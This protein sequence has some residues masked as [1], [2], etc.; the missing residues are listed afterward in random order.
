[1]AAAAGEPVPAADTGLA[2]AAREPLPA[3]DARLAPAQPQPGY[4]PPAWTAAP[5]QPKPKPAESLARA[6]HRN[7]EA[8]LKHLRRDREA[9]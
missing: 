5:G 1:M 4:Y 9:A 3:A 8:R 6:A 2:D 7:V